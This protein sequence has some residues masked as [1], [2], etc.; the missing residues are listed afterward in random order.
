MTTVLEDT[1]MDLPGGAFWDGRWRK[2]GPWTD[3]RNQEDGSAI[4]RV[5][6][7][8]PR[9]VDLAVQTVAKSL[10][11]D[12]AWPAWERRDALL[13]AS[14]KVHDQAE[15]FARTISRESSK[16]ITAARAEV[17]RTVET[18]RLSAEQIS[19]LSGETLG[20]DGTPRGESRIGW[21]TR[22]PVGVVA[23]ITP[24]ND[25]LNLVAHKLGPALIGGNGVVL[26]PSDQTPL[27]ALLLAQ[28]LLQSG[29]PARR[30]AV[31]PG[32]G[33][34][35]GHA[36]VTHPSVDL[37]SFTGGFATGD[38]IAK[39]AGARKMLMEL[40]GIG[41]VI[42]LDDADLEDAATQIVGGAFGNAG[43]NC[44]S[45][46]RVLVA[47]SVA[48]TLTAKVIE[49]T[50]A[51]KVGSKAEEDTDVGP[52]I[53]ETAAKRVESWVNEAIDQGARLETGGHRKGS[54]YEPSVLTA[55]PPRARLM[56][57]E[58]FG[59]VVSI[60]EV[61]DAASAVRLANDTEFGLQAGIFTADV[62][63]AL[64]LASQLQMGAVMIND[65]GDFRIDSMPFGG[66]KHSGIGREGVR[67]A[68]EAMTEPK[69]VA[70]RHR[71]H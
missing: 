66:G 42:V 62:D 59:P 14:Q 53:N 23:A 24:F 18:L 51:V 33:I 35:V 54:F 11:E 22:E 3:V 67:Y 16:P 40:G 58:V 30:L 45:V 57:E 52:M 63:Y 2:G 7:G 55:V 1:R 56:Q 34:E 9:D 19:R 37:V 68:M 13:R 38:A 61:D 69:I 4:G 70:I 20:F 21:Y 49:R 31:V 32:H 65:T 26:K 6:S 5:V 43:Q 29:V 50:K 44:L 28:V 25:P 10:K 27:T 8:T 36:L 64:Q 46:Q 60:V 41:S 12:P 15:R 39:A 48:T 71:A 17:A 47:S